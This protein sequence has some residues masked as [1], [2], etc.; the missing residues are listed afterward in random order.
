MTRRR[1]RLTLILFLFATAAVAL[2]AFLLG[3]S[4]S[5][6]ANTPFPEP[7]RSF[8]R[9]DGEYSAPETLIQPLGPCDRLIGPDG[10]R[11]QLTMSACGD[12]VAGVEKMAPK[13]QRRCS[14]LRRAML[15]S[16]AGDLEPAVARMEPAGLPVLTHDA[17]PGPGMGGDGLS[18]PD[19]APRSLFSPPP[20]ALVDGVPTPAGPPP[21]PP[22]DPVPI[23]APAALLLTGLLAIGAARRRAR[24]S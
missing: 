10:L 19:G 20:F 7:D 11:G 2:L 13:L 17:A 14:P 1:I 9:H 21:G 8:A 23:P 16:M 4:R 15:D 12:V 6:G 3:S 18:F 5:A 24:A 22:V